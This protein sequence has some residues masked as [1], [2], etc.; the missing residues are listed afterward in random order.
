MIPRI[1][2]SVQ[3]NDGVSEYLSDVYAQ[4]LW[5]RFY[6]KPIQQLNETGIEGIA[7]LAYI[8]AKAQGDT[9]QTFDDWAKGIQT[10]DMET[11]DSNP[12]PPVVSNEN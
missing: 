7:Y 5:Q 8:V 12:T 2:V 9:K 4:I 10:L 6:T 11:I 3:R 1:K